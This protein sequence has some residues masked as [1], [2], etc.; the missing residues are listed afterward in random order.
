[1]ECCSRQVSG[2]SCVQWVRESIYV[3]R[4][5]V[6]DNVGMTLNPSGL[7]LSWRSS[8]PGPAQPSPARKYL[9]LFLA[10]LCYSSNVVGCTGRRWKSWSRL[11]FFWKS[12]IG[13]RRI[14]RSKF[15][16]TSLNN[17]QSRNVKKRSSSLSTELK[18]DLL[19][20][21]KEQYFFKSS[22]VSVFCLLVDLFL[23]WT[24]VASVLR[25]RKRNGSFRCCVLAIQC[26]DGSL[27][28]T[29]LYSSTAVLWCFSRACFLCTSAQR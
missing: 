10:L 20:G 4:S 5:F 9:L 23:F 8:R 17:A 29:N 28:I 7:C 2:I 12:L 27:G 11:L 1:M 13:S 3:D 22:F 14:V 19:K 15:S 6:S 26:W 16:R 24:A 25:A 21:V 18:I